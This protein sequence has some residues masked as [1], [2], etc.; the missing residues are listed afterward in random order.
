MTVKLRLKEEP[1][2]PIL[3]LLKW[4]DED[5]VVTRANDTRYG[6]A[7]SVWGKD[8]DAA[9]RI[10]LRERGAGRGLPGAGSQT[11]RFAFSIAWSADVTAP[12]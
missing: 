6:L 1:F 4:R 8:L 7:A 11:R 9:Q 10:G 2:G 3:P 5:D 12:S